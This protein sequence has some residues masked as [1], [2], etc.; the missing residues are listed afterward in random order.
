M[1]PVQDVALLEL[2]RRGLEDVRARAPGRGVKERHD[3][4]ELVAITERAA[5]LIEGGATEYASGQRLIEQ[6]ID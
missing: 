1:P 5:R 2:V 6:A 3:V 4:L